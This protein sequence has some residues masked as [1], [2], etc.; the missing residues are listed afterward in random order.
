M[1]IS[2]TDIVAGQPVLQI[3]KLLKGG[4]DWGIDRE[5]VEHILGVDAN[6]AEQILE[7]LEKDGYIKRDQNRQ[8]ELHWTNTIKGNALAHASAANPVK[9]AV[10]ERNLDAFLSRVQQINTSTQYAYRV[11]TVILFGSYLS[12]AAT[13]NDVD[14][15]VE[16]VARRDD[17]KEMELLR[18]QRVDAATMEGRSF[19]SYVDTLLW[20]WQ[21]VWQF[22]KARSRVISLHNLQEEEGFLRGVSHEVLIGVWPPSDDDSPPK[23]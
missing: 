9:R 5:L 11:K 3:R 13:V 2:S 1:H 20:P 23:E 16:L 10:A 19:K 17:L 8:R 7:E 15:A 12:N 22:L 4:R 14:L 21:E 6:T 18:Q